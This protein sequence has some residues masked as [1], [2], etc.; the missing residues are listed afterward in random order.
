[1][2][3]K[4]KCKTVQSAKKK[5]TIVKGVMRI[6]EQLNNLLHKNITRH[7]TDLGKRSF[8]YPDSVLY[9]EDFPLS[10]INSYKEILQKNHQI[11]FHVIFFFVNFLINFT[12]CMQIR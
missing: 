10:R 6:I 4:I 8:Y 1:M 12:T 9:I 7:D 3:E 5:F 11:Y 2:E